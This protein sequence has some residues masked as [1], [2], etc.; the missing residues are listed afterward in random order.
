MN[1]VWSNK[2]GV[3]WSLFANYEDGRITSFEVG[4]DCPYYESGYTVA[5]VIYNDDGDVETILGPWGE[6]YTFMGG[7][8]S[9]GLWKYDAWGDWGEPWDDYN[10]Q[11]NC[12]PGTTLTNCQCVSWWAS[13]DGA[14]FDGNGC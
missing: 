1:Y 8:D 7:A 9:P 6:P 12:E 5:Q 4:P 10:N 13:C 14:M 11:L 3:T 2:A